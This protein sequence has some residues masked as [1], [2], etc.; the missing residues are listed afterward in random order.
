MQHSPTEFVLLFHS[1]DDD[2]GQEFL[3]GLV[4]FWTGYPSL[5]TEPTTVMHLKCL[6]NRANKALAEANTCPLILSIPVV[7]EEYRIF[8]DH[9]D[10][11]NI[12]D[13]THHSCFCCSCK[14]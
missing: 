10:E 14:T 12:L 11:Y 1:I 4:Q 9:L 13:P 6:A 7:H 3:H 2:K 8:K 5:P